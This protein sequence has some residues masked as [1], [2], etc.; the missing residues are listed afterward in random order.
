MTRLYS[1]STGNLYLPGV[2]KDIPG[3]A[4]K[5]SDALVLSVIGNPAP[6]KIRDHDE[7]GLPFL[8]DSP[9]P[10][11]EQLAAVE[12]I[13]RDVQL[14]ATDGIINRHR[15][16]V[17]A[18]GATTLTVEQYKVL[19]NYRQDLRNWPDASDFPESVKRP[20]APIWLVEQLNQ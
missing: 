10:S 16:Q 7:N 19:Q 4:V 20:V 1:K 8:V 2:N 17:E 14:L 3:D 6:G 9:P 11:A 15:D 5:I 12:R 18:G 13:W